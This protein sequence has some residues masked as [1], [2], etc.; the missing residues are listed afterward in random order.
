MNFSQSRLD[1]PNLSISSSRPNFSRFTQA[2]D[3]SG[4]Y[5]TFQSESPDFDSMAARNIFEEAST[6]AEQIRADAKIR[7][8]EYQ[9][10]EAEKIAKKAARDARNQARKDDGKNTSSGIGGVLGTVAGGVIGGPIGAGIGGILG[11]GIG[12]L[13]G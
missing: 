5:S 13:F 2:T 10:N 9:K 7:A 1:L 3:L 11:K 4:I 8:S 6:E 12:G